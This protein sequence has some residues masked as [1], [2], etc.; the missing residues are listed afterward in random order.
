[1]T[2]FPLTLPSPLKGEEFLSSGR[3]PVGSSVTLEIPPAPF[4]KGEYLSGF[5]FEM[6]FEAGAGGL[7]KPFQSFGGRMH[8]SP[9]QAGNHRLGGFHFAGQLGQ[10]H[11]GFG[12][13]FDNGTGEFEFRRKLF[14]L[15][16]ISGVF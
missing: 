11:S 14:I 5:E 10:R 16:F 9:F 4:T 3:G 12:A 15:L 6:D 2:N 8:P 7:C 13:G 1:M